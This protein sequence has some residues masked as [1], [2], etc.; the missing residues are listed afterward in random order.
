[1]YWTFVKAISQTWDRYGFVN[2]HEVRI[3]TGITLVLWL[4]SLFLVLFKG[5]YEI[6]LV[7]LWLIWLD[8]FLKVFISP[9]FALFGNIV[10][11]C[12]KKRE[13][14]WV[15]S[16]QKRFARSIG[17]AISSFVLFCLLV[18]W[19]HLSISWPMIQSIWQTTATNLQQGALVVV[20]MNLAIIACLLCIIFM[21]LESVAGYCVWCTIYA[22]LV[23][24]WIMK[25]HPGQNCVNGVCEVS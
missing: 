10:R 12:I 3:A 22:W 24:K 20:P 15:W 17:L 7:L 5:N 1:M 4:F 23:K 2:E 9:K 25:K 6:P 16:V 13:P 14:Q 8:F 11:L 21:R 19:D 18:L